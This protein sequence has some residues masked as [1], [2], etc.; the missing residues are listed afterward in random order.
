MVCEEGENA[1]GG[2]LERTRPIC[3]LKHNGEGKT[4]IK[5]WHGICF[6]SHIKAGKKHK[7]KKKN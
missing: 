7:K 4:G 1:R 5:A 3:F 6:P 2:F